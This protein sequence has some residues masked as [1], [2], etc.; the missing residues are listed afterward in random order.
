M[1]EVVRH[2]NSDRMNT[3]KYLYACELSMYSMEM[4][5]YILTIKS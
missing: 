4:L 1:C 5:P 2:S 3:V